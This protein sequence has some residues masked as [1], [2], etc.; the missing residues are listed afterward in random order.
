VVC[1][2]CFAS[3]AAVVQVKGDQVKVD[4]SE[5]MPPKRVEAQYMSHACI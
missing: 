2:Y 4:P 3:P 5:V 1:R